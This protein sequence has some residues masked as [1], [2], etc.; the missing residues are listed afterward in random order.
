MFK[1]PYKPINI[2]SLAF[3]GALT[4]T[5][6]FKVLIG[7]TIVPPENVFGSELELDANTGEI[8]SIKHTPAGNGKVA[9]LEALELKLQM[10]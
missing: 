4:L 8:C 10:S 1:L 7:M 9:V 2:S 5:F 6:K 3:T